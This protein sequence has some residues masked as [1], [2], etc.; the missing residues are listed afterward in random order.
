MS[1]AI[2]LMEKL[3]L[4]RK[5]LPKGHRMNVF[6]GFV[7]LRFLCS[8]YEAVPVCSRWS[9]MVVGVNE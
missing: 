9:L 7:P 5:V 3:R 8:Q 4:N 1:T 6:L 2:R